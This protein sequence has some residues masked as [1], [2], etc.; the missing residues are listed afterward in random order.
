MYKFNLY[1]ITLNSYVF[2]ITY[3][4]ICKNNHTK[5]TLYTYITQTLFIALFIYIKYV[6]EFIYKYL[7]ISFI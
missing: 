4:I 1:L 7:F 5:Y 3:I 2:I 6:D